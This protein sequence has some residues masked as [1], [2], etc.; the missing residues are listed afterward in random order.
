MIFD[1]SVSA[2]DTKTEEKIL[3][4][5]RNLRHNKTTIMVSHRISTV[6]D[7]DMIILLDEGKV[8]AIGNHNELLKSSPLY[9]EMVRLQT[10][11]EEVNND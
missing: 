4:N 1:D 11:E 7:L 8:V 10:L 6:K 9:Q 3:T 2:V 5:L